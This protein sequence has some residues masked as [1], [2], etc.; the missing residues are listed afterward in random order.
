MKKENIAP[1]TDVRAI[2]SEETMLR[3]KERSYLVC[4]LDH[5]PLHQTCLRWLVGQ[6]ADAT[7]PSYRAVNP[8]YPH[9]ATDS[10]ELYR[11]KRCAQVMYGFTRL[12]DNMPARMAHR[13]RLFLI[14]QFGHK[15]YYE[16]RKGQRPINP[17]Q[18]T[19]ILDACRQH[20]WQGP[21]TYDRQEEDYD[22]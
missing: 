8:H 18:Q 3:S 20:G 10:C 9:T 21:V 2:S 11:E 16:M 4:F 15:Y 22:W 12:F 5:C 6:Y 14:M 17:G 19:V 1:R 7:Q 13:I